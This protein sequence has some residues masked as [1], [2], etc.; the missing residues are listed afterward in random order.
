M[1]NYSPIFVK[2]AQAESFKNTQDFPSEEIP[3]GYRVRSPLPMEEEPCP[4]SLSHGFFNT[5]PSQ[6]WNSS[7]RNFSLAKSIIRT[8]NLH[9]S[10][11]KKN[12]PISK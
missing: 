9:G 6:H 11:I 3:L 10:Q 5:Q 2:L 4:L 12:P 1:L 8:C 7:F